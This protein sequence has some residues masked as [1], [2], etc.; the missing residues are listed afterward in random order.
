MSRKMFN[1]YDPLLPFPQQARLGVGVINSQG[2]HTPPV[3]LVGHDVTGQ[4]IHGPDNEFYN[5]TSP[6]VLI[7]LS[8]GDVDAIKAARAA[9]AQ[10]ER[11]ARIANEQKIKNE[12]GQTGGL[13]ETNERIDDL[14]TLLQNN[15]LISR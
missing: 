7:P 10:A 13:P 15:G 1:C 11:D 6:D 14:I 9:A 5:T 2:Q 8:Q 3:G 4:L 12:K